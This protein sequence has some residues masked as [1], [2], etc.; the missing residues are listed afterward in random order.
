VNAGSEK[1]IMRILHVFRSPVGGL[2]RHVRDLARAQAALG[3]DVGIFCDSST[4]G[5]VAEQLLSDTLPFCSLGITR[6]V[7]SKLPGFGDVSTART[8]QRLAKKLNI[9]VIHGHGAKGGLYG[10]LAGKLSGIAS[11]Y[12]PHG[13]SLHFEW[14]TFP[15]QFFLSTEWAMSYAGSGFIFVCEFERALFAKKVGLAGRPSAVVHNGLWPEEFKPPTLNANATDLLFVGEM[16][17][18]KGVDVLLEAL[19][20]LRK[21]NPVTLT[22]VGAGAEKAEFEALATRLQ[23]GTAVRFVGHQSISA[24]LTMGKMM[25][26]P[27][28]NESFPYVV[29][30]TVAAAV[31]IVATDVGG[32]AEVLPSSMLCKSDDKDDLAEKISLKLGHFS[33]TQKTAKE[34]VNRLKNDLSANIMASKIVDFYATIIAR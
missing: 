21:N 32:I 30:E 18:L 11:V 25:V 22:L 29:L 3:H 2:F 5:A 15:G 8:V 17:K 12:T 34:L 13:G 27:S 31:P 33:E 14:N 23:L 20:K 6:S 19:A 4:G 1:E 24:A 9:D 26:L 28:R 10:R 16:R 7:I